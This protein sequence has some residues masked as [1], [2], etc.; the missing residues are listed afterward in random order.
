[1]EETKKEGEGKE[2]R[3]GENIAKEGTAKEGKE[4][5]REVGKEPA[6]EGVTAHVIREE[7]TGRWLPGSSPNPLGRPTAKRER[8]VIEAIGARVHPE[9][10]AE[11]IDDLLNH[12]SSWRAWAAGL[13][14]YGKY[15][16]GPAPARTPE[17]ENVID[18]ILAKMRDARG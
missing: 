17:S 12:P 18:V 9:M 6:K 10:V 14:W 16:L 11:R 1:M 3:E 7:K 2:A 4:A 8:A 5:A 15:M 13:E